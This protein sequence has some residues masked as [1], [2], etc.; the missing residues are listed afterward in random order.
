MTATLVLAALLGIVLALL[1]V[2]RSR[3]QGLVERLGRLNER[4]RALESDLPAGVDL[5]TPLSLRAQCSY[6][7]W[8]VPEQRDSMK[9][10]FFRSAREQATSLEVWVAGLEAGRDPLRGAKGVSLRAFRSPVE[11]DIATYSL[12]VPESYDSGR[13]WPLIVHLHG[14][15]KLHP[16]QGHPAP[17]YG[18]EVLV[19]APHGKGSV[20]YMGPAEAD[21]LGAIAEAQRLYNVDADRVY[22]AGASMG[23]TGAWHL[24]V[25]Y[26]DR[27]A[28]LVAASANSDD[29]VWEDL[30][31][32]PLPEPSEGSV[33]WALKR[34][35]RLDSP[36]TYAPN[37]LGVPSRVL[38]GDDDAVVPV[39]HARSMVTALEE[40][41]ADTEYHELVGVGHNL[42]YGETRVEQAEW[43]LKH[44]RKSRPAVIRYL[45]DGRWPGAYWLTRV[46]PEAPLVL[47]EVR[48]EV[49]EEERVELTVKGCAAAELDLKAAPL[50]DAGPVDVIVNG[51]MAGSFKRG[52]VTLARIGGKW[53]AAKT[54]EEFC[55]K[56]FS[57]LFWRSFVI[58]YGTGA[59]DAALGAALRRAAERLAAGWRR[60]Y[61]ASPRVFADTEVPADVLKKSGL[62][63]FG[64]PGE[65][66]LTARA[67]KELSLTGY[68]APF[69]LGPEGPRLSADER[70]GADLETLGLQFACPSPF[71]PGKALAVIWGRGWRSLVDVG[72][73]FGNSFDWT[74][75]E[76][77]GWF[78]YA[79]YDAKTCT[80]ESFL[81]VGLYG[82]GWKLDPRYSWGREGSDASK[83]PGGAPLYREVSEAPAGEVLRLDQVL[84][85]E[86]H[87]MR[88]PVGYGRG[89]GGGLLRAGADSRAFDN[90]LGVKGPSRLVYELGNGF[91][92]LR[93]TIGAD[94]GGKQ[95]A[96]LREPRVTYGTM[97]FTVRGD[98]K[99]LYV[100]DPLGPAEAAADI[101][102]DVAGVNRL[103]LKVVAAGK[104]E[105]HLGSG[106][107][108]NARLE[109]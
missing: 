66:A 10:W 31:E 43:L 20:D 87:Q 13:A 28:A 73:R 105:W 85:T 25:H 95:L 100:S 70:A 2:R 98:G 76:N 79:L 97:T 8:T 34:L 47:A 61:F 75:Y 62:V 21:V 33:D 64:G 37:L 29:R 4:L 24:A 80:P 30:W 109:K 7:Q 63:L 32:E 93:A 44:R 59:D 38:H 53:Q 84:P 46:V 14:R 51:V 55:P 27:F 19:L 22:L 101:E 49:R 89:W 9:V 3:G 65:N 94:I 96:D 15:G 41:G 99:L 106:A 40:A 103:E 12:R 90:G 88:G 74:V 69:E 17:A 16:F 6:L 58:V 52:R 83:L 60:R 86:V 92:R 39:E 81:R 48:A 108:G 42:S 91:R 82:P 45:T 1:L 68:K 36:V 5:A 26:P 56:E 107:W 77:R 35:E 54:R 104:Y 78:G 18:E 57:H 50:K 102:V 71:A 23:G 11:G 72:N 67:L